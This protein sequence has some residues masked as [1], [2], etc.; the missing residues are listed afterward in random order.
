MA[1][2][3]AT[4]RPAG[5]RVR[6]S[7]RAPYTSVAGC[8]SAPVTMRVTS[9]AAAR[10]AGMLKSRLTH[11][12]P[13]RARLVSVISEQAWPTPAPS[14]HTALHTPVAPH[15]KLSSTAASPSPYA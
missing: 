4:S 13:I 7:E 8:G 9:M 5:S 1:A 11:A 3:R 2:E 12:L 14:R 6:T 10:M 15:A